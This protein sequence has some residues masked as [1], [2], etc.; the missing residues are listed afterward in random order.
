MP[1]Q[2][3]D[4]SRQYRRMSWR[5]AGAQ[6]YPGGAF[7]TLLELSHRGRGPK[8]YRPTDERLTEIICERLTEDPFI[9]ASEVTIRVDDGEVILEGRV[10][11]RQQKFA[12][13]DVIADIA[14]V[15]DIHNRL[16]VGNDDLER[17]TSG[18]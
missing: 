7:D 12:I 3:D 17:R 15:A 6:D 2:P 9:D 4:A 8:G 16:T 13:E 5:A 14:G 18:L 1:T 10:S 11:V